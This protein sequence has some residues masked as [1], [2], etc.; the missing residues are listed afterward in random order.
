MT[1]TAAAGLLAIGLIIVWWIS[2]RPARGIYCSPKW[3]ADQLR[4][5]GQTGR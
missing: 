3:I 1:W 2:R 4:R 5:D